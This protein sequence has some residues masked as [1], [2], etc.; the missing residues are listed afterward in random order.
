MILL[1][2]NQAKFEFEKNSFL[3]QLQKLFNEHDLLNN[4]LLILNHFFKDSLQ[5]QTDNDQKHYQPYLQEEN[6]TN[7]NTQIKV[8]QKKE[9]ILAFD[10][11][12]QYGH[13]K[14]I[15]YHFEFI[16]TKQQTIEPYRG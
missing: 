3:E 13:K 11:S 2:L 15:K 5:G 7:N 4:I 6:F 16:I 8:N 10:T 1:G 14:L 9:R 12:Y